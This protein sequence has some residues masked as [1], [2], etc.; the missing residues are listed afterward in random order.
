MD[1]YL[2]AWHLMAYDYAGSWAN[3]TGHDAN[4]YHCAE[5]PASTPFSTDAAVQAYISAGVNAS[6]I[7]MGM[8]I[9][10]RSF[11]NTTG[12]GKSYNRIGSGTW[13]AGVYDYKALPL[14]GS[15]VTHDIVLGASYSYDA[16]S[17]QLISYDTIEIVQQKIGYI[18]E[19][20]LGGAMFW[21]SSADG[22]GNL[23]LILA[24]GMGL[25]GLDLGE[26]WLGY[27]G[28]RYDNVA[29][30]MGNGTVGVG[31]TY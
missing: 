10:G 8:P 6:K 7:I 5:S 26:N 4:L 18:K 25:G 19:R 11:E 20:G 29:D 16:I 12:I 14:P 30:N 22:K 28:S 3:V 15:K 1:T 23:S 9:Y 17:K 13:E 27:L 31:N 2:D 21:E 24:A